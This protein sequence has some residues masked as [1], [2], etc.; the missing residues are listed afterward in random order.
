M[1]DHGLNEE[2][3]ETTVGPDGRYTLTDIPLR[4]DRGYIATVEYA[5][6]SFNSDMVIG[7]P[8]RLETALDVTI[9]ETTTDPGVLEIEAVIMQIDHVEG[10]V[11]VVQLTQFNNTSNMM[12]VSA[13]DE[14]ASVHVRLPDGARLSEQDTDLRRVKLSE[15]AR[16][17]YDTRPVLPGEQHMLHTVYAMPPEA[18][19][20]QSFDYPLE[21]FIEIYV[22]SEAIGID[23]LNHLGAQQANGIVYQAYGNDLSL[24]SGDLLEFSIRPATVAVPSSSPFTNE[25][26]AYGLMVAGAVTLL[27]AVGL[28]IQSRRVEARK[29]QG[30]SISA[31]IQTLMQQVAELDNRHQSQS[32]DEPT[33]QR[34]RA[35]LKSEIKMLMESSAAAGD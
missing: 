16:T 19:I 29:P 18:D 25:T 32:I 5:G 14:L 8:Q 30:E 9:Y 20:R 2:R 24:A 4:S 28:F 34:E 35:R 10:G 6:Q 27:L 33:Y 22:G 26:L 21:G 11:G 31:R 15:D 13:E 1:L 3:F 12:Y 17:V 7:N 23:G